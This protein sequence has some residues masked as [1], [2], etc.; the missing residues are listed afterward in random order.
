MLYPKEYKTHTNIKHR[1]KDLKGISGPVREQTQSRKRD[2]PA[3][4]KMS[5][6]P[7]R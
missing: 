3:T 2:D 5:L 4:L 6:V 1:S 7:K